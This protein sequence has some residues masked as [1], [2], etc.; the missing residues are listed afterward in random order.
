[1][2][3]IFRTAALLVIL[4]AACSKEPAGPGEA[5]PAPAQTAPPAAEAAAAPDNA[6][7]EISQ[8]VAR[9]NGRPVYRAFYEQTLGYMRSR[10][11][12]L[13]PA[14]SVEAYLR[15]RSDAMERL[16]EDELIYQEAEKQGLKV[17]ETKVQEELSRLIQ[18]AGSQAAYI[19]RMRSQHLSEK[20]VLEGIRR[21]MTVDKFLEE[22]IN[23]RIEVTD[24]EVVGYYNANQ[25]KFST[26]MWVRLAHILIR[27]PRD[28]SPGLLSESR[29]RAEKLLANLHAG[30]S[31]ETL[32]RDFSEDASAALG[33]NL[34][35]MRRGAVPYPEFEAIAF[36]LPPG[37]PSE[38]VQTDVG[39]HIILVKERVG[40]KA[41]EFDEVKD[42]CREG[43]RKAKQAVLLAGL[44]QELKSKAKIEVYL[45]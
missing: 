13:Q 15:A 1:M 25:K 35:M 40:G 36:S 34:G 6:E 42:E 11:E 44:G 14:N 24:D 38:V 10:I 4:L 37:Q 19:T 2:T 9:V 29:K 28:A 18:E 27:C 3:P 45:Q 16:I 39:F 31:F 32:A 12:K 7:A 41:K 30:Q 33:G 26:T 23:P 8:V 17:D 22:R 21:R 5:A 20:N 43:V